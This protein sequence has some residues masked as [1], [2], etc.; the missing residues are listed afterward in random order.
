MEKNKIHIYELKYDLYDL[1]DRYQS[2]RIIFLNQNILQQHK[3]NTT[4]EVV[5]ALLYGIPYPQVYVSELQ[6]GQLLV[7]ETDNKLRCLIEFIVGKFDV[8]RSEFLRDNR[9]IWNYFDYRSL[10]QSFNIT[11]REKQEILRT[12]IP[13][14]IIEYETPR[15][16]HLRI[17][18]YIEKWSIE[19]EE[20]VRRILYAD[21]GMHILREAFREQGK[22]SFGLAAEAE[23]VV[24]LTYIVNFIYN[25]Q[26]E[27]VEDKYGMQENMLNFVCTKGVD[28]KRIADIYI[29]ARK[30]FI[31]ASIY[32]KNEN[33][34]ISALKRF[35]NR[36]SN[37]KPVRG[38]LLGMAVCLCSDIYDVQEIVEKGNDIVKIVFEKDYSKEIE[39]QLRNSDLS[40]ESIERILDGLRRLLYD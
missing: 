40:K 21:K 14:C 11:N 23:F 38:H 35:S 17:G 13:L 24:F 16:M 5:E 6:N 1:V 9:N 20:A 12:K 31:Q 2:K 34:E 4:R 10:S 36:F 27:C 39:K 33:V 30:Y 15:Y 32:H 3:V 7:L 19:R 26:G 18:A 37:I 8:E 29:G 22:P 25:Y 28:I